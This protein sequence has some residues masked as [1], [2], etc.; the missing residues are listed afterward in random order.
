MAEILHAPALYLYPLL[1][2][3]LLGVL[4][5]VLFFVGAGHFDHAG[6][7]H[8]AFEHVLETLHLDEAFDW[9]NFGRVPFSILLLLLLVTFGMVG[10]ML[11]Q[12]VPVLPVW[13]YAIG[14]VPASIAVTKITGGWIAYLL[15]RDESYAVNRDGLVGRR[16]VVTLGPLDDGPPGNVLV[17]DQHGELHTLRARPA[18][19]GRR[20]EKG[21]EI[22]VVEAASGQANVYLVM[23]FQEDPFEEG[24]LEEGHAEP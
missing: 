15:P 21:A 10:I 16:G 23:P 7:G 8:G 4:Q 24:P 2:G 1:A 12:I 9:L 13:S 5:I 22:V 11:W 14:A 20:I 18:D 3:L 19:A 17:R 6:G